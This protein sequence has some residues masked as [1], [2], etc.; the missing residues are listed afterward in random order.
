[1]PISVLGLKLFYYNMRQ[2]AWTLCD[3]CLDSNNYEW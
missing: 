3:I 1:M 2:V